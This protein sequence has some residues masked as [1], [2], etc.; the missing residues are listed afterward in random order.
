M[1]APPFLLK[2]LRGNLSSLLSNAYSPRQLDEMVLLCH[3]LAV[4]SIRGKLASGKISTSLLGL[5]DSDLA[6]DC[7]ADLFQRDET[8]KVIH[9]NTYFESFLVETASDEALLA[10]LRRLIFA[11][12]NQSLFRLYNETDPSLGKII[13]N[14]K[15]AIHTFGNFV[16]IDKFG[17]SYIAPSLCDPMLELAEIEQD[18][19]Q[20]LIQQACRGRERIPEIL[21]R[22]S[23]ALRQQKDNS[24][25]VRLMAVAYAVRSFLGETELQTNEEPAVERSLLIGDALSVIRESCREVRAKNLPKYVGK[26]KVT[27]QHYEQY[28]LVIERRLKEIFI[29]HDGEDYSLFDQLSKLLPALTSE[30]YKRKHKNILEYLSRIT[31]ERAR[32][33]L[34]NE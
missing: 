6:Y 7:I 25:A 5:N 30:E 11:R 26:M 20:R 15:L 19:L 31:Y 29:G 10:H 8:G 22:L 1:A 27:Q 2:N 23:S 4:T 28:F 18:A 9:L 12:V 16:D 17:E 14:I 33:N 21:A 32:E 24:R 13:R 34:K 3:S